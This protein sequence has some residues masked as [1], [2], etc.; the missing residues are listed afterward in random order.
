LDYADV[1]D[2]AGTI[3]A[4]KW[5]REW[6]KKRKAKKKQPK[7]KKDEDSSD[8]VMEPVQEPLNTFSAFLKILKLLAILYLLCSL[9]NIPLL[10][11]PLTVSEFTPI[12]CISDSSQIECSSGLIG[13]V[14]AKGDCDLFGPKTT[15]D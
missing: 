4:Y 8:E 15:I 3:S 11:N 10:L 2:F 7:E 9:V 12:N 6:W 1:F 5:M 13:Q 14:Y